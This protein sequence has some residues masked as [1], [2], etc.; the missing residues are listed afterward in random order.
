MSPWL[1]AIL[2]DLFLYIFRQ[3]WYW[4]PVWGAE[5]EDRLDPEH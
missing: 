1:I 4:L 3:A 2:V 5:H